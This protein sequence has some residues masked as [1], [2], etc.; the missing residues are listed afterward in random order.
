MPP[1]VSRSGQRLRGFSTGHRAAW[2]YGM[3]LLAVAAATAARYGFEGALGVYVLYLPYVTVVTIVSFLGGTGPGLLAGALSAL[4]VDWFF[5]EPYGSWWI[6]STAK[7]WA[8]ALFVATAASIALMVGNLRG[9]LLAR[10]RMEEALRRQSELIDLAHDA[11]VTMDRSR[12]IIKW[13]IGAEELYGWSEREAVGQVFHQL[14][15]S[16]PPI[17][18]SQIDEILCREGRWEGEFLQFA[19]D[20]RRLIVDSRQLLVGTGKSEHIL[21][22]NRDITAQNRAVEALRTSQQRLEM[23]LDA[24]NTG[25]WDLDLNTR[26]TWRSRQHDEIFG[27]PEPVKHWTYESFLSHV[28]PE[29]R[30]DIDRI[31]QQAAANGSAIEFECKIRRADGPVRWIWSKGDTYR[32]SQ[33]HPLGMSG[34]VQ[35]ITARKQME[36]AL[37]QSEEQFR[38]FANALPNPCAIADAEGRFFWFNQRWSDYTG[39]TV[40]QG[41]GW[42]WLSAIVHDQSPGWR[43]SWRE[44]IASGHPFESV[45]TVRGA[46]GIARPFLAKAVPLCDREGKVVRWFGSMTDISEQR[47]IEE[48]LRKAH[49]EELAHA[50]ELQAIMD[51][52]PIAMFISRDP[53]CRTVIGNRSA[54]DLFHEPAGVNLSPDAPRVAACRMMQNGQQVPAHQLPM[55]RAAATGQTVYDQELDLVYADGSHATIVGNAVPLLNAEGRSTGAIGIFMDITARKLMEEALRKAHGE[56]LARATE[57]Q[58][59]MDAAPIAMFISRDRE[60]RNVI[61]N[62]RAY[63]LLRLPA[64]SNPSKSWLAFP[65]PPRFQMAQTTTEIPSDELPLQKAATTGQAVDEQEM[66]LVFPDG[67][68]TNVVGNAVPF[69]DSEGRF[70]GAIGILVDITER[71]RTE[72]RLRQAQK[73]ESIGMLAGGIAHDFNNLLTVIVGSADL[74]LRSCPSCLEMRHVV[75]SAERAAHLTRQL[76]AYAGKGHFVS[77][78]F[79][80]KDLVYRCNALLAASVPKSVHLSFNLSPEELLLKADPTQIE[81]ILV[82]LVINAAESISPQSSGWIEIATS[83]CVISAEVAASQAPP[84]E[85]KPGSFV[86]LQVTDNGS[87]MDQATLAQIF[88]PFFSTK[89]TGRGLGLA[90]VQGIVRSYHGFVEVK[91]APGVGSTFRIFLPSAHKDPLALLPAGKTSADSRKQARTR[92]VILVADDEDMVRGLACSAL[93]EGGYEVWE[94]QDGQSALDTIAAA[95]EP[96]SVL[97]LD[98]SMPGMEVEELVPILHAKYPR[99]RIILTSGYPEEEARARVPS[100]AVT[101]FL[102]KPYKLAALM[103]AVEDALRSG[104]SP[105]DRAPAAA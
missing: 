85:A 11:V 7:L 91:S 57:L 81:Q 15:Q 19:R 33:G 27:Y 54:N 97:L 87:G 37:Q 25:G 1:G 61:G 8:F 9:S 84:Y 103:K 32:D 89:F 77:E 53:E 3:A 101:G 45:L 90:A 98:V 23:V 29:Y 59:I 43:E 69:L 88:D 75:N 30:E 17:P 26:E 52:A 58:A 4:A 38:T 95:V 100:E 10:A 36:E 78:T 72:E 16:E 20:G 56:E 74:A 47:K 39:L 82:N 14:L 63:E 71:K 24:A 40:E 31:V 18:V 83:S 86:C 34:I 96:P 64:G 5:L 62:R 49:S 44:S 2:Q 80:L 105:L 68:R 67:T 50:T 66:D 6:D 28:L 41:R 99:V 22:I 51:A 92:Q 73:L 35:D 21:A 60:C 102:Q 76:L 94:A 70:A 55:Q 12:R 65:T 48:A 93:R 42:A 46:D 13:N 79:D 104:G